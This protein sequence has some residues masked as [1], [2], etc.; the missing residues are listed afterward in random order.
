MIRLM[1]QRVGSP[2]W[3]P[4]C[5]RRVQRPA[6]SNAVAGSRAVE[7]DR[8]GRPLDGSTLATGPYLFLSSSQN[9]DEHEGEVGALRETASEHRRWAEVLGHESER[10]SERMRAMWIRIRMRTVLALALSA[11]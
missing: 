6:R 11:V 7:N 8:T 2:W 1:Q 3:A 4:R 9:D 10:R 5:G